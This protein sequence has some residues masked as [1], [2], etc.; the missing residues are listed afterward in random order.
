MTKKPTKFANPTIGRIELVDSE[1]RWLVPLRLTYCR[2]S[3]RRDTNASHVAASQAS[4][5]CQIPDSGA[6]RNPLCR[7]SRRSGL[8]CREGRIIDANYERA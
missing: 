1:P 2:G 4:D 6:H 3:R 5:N 8:N 7:P